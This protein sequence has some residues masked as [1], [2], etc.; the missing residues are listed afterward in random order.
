MVSARAMVSPHPSLWRF[1][2]GLVLS[3]FMFI[4]FF[5]ALGVWGCSLLRAAGPGWGEP[6]PFFK[7]ALDREEGVGIWV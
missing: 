7:V 2:A 5:A 4:Q 1:V 6:K 3:E